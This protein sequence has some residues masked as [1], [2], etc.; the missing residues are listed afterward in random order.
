MW[1]SFL[2]SIVG[3]VSTTE[4]KRE[5]TVPE[6]KQDWEL[7]RPADQR[8]FA[9]ITNLHPYV[10]KLVKT[11]LY[12]ARQAGL[13][14]YI[15]EGY[16]T[17]ERQAELY[18]KGRDAQGRLVD[19]KKVVTFAAPGSSFHNYALAVDIVFDGDIKKPGI[20]WSWDVADN[21][22]TANNEAAERRKLWTDLGTIM[23]QAG[24]E[25]AGTWK[26]FREMPHAQ[27]STALTIGQLQE[28]YKLGGLAQVWKLVDADLAAKG[29]R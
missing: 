9:L 23:M 12:R 24:L 22:Q 16:R 5:A 25:W 7:Y 8:E 3:A 1:W 20:Q 6:P 4:P 19:K 13:P 17:W 10:Q 18:A 15:F 27:L 26:S 11:V 14:V 21:P 28:A 29:L 2:K